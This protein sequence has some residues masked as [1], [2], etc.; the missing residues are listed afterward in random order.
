MPASTAGIAAEPSVHTLQLT[1][2][3]LQLGDVLPGGDELVGHQV[4]KPVP[5]GH[6]VVAVHRG[7]QLA[8]L[9]QAQS[10]PLRL[11]DE[12]H[13]GD[14]LR[15]VEPIADRR[16]PNRHDQTLGFIEA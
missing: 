13:P 3:L 11:P 9:G 10:E 14:L 5:G 7:E 6:G 16:P 2:K 15:I 4:A 1:R 12:P 8:D